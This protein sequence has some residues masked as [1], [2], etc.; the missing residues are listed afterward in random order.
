MPIPNKKSG[1]YGVGQLRVLSQ[2]QDLNYNVE[3]EVMRSG[4]NKNKWDY[5]NVEQ[6]ATTFR[7]QPILCAYV[8]GKIGDG[9]NM[10]ETISIDG[11]KRYSFTAPDAERIVGMIFDTDDAIRTVKKGSQTWV[12][13]KGKLWRFY[14]PE[15]VDK[16]AKQKRMEVSAETN[17]LE[18]VHEDGYDVFLKWYGV[19]VTILG[20]NV[21]PAIPGANIKALQAMEQSFKELC[22]KAAS[23]HARN[24]KNN[25]GANRIVNGMK[26]KILLNE[27]QGKF[28]DYKVIGMNDDG[29]HVVM[30]NNT[31]AVFTYCSKEDDHGVVIPERISPVTLNSTHKFEDGTAV[32]IDVMA[33]LSDAVCSVTDRAS[34]AETKVANLEAE[35]T[36]LQEQMKAMNEAENKRRTDE[37]ERAVNDAIE[38][39]KKLGMEMPEEVNSILECAKSGKY[40]NSCNEKGDWIGVDVAIN[41]VMAYIGRQTMK[42]NQQAADAQMNSRFNFETFVNSQKQIDGSDVQAVI[43]RNL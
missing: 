42:E 3:I 32:E 14:N 34:T 28:P 37:V 18:Q 13:A 17:I 30:V 5:R 21:S 26:N 4:P 25:E 33:M 36:K 20:D 27:I 22:L 2:D 16:I 8:N 24:E 39:A 10:R 41:E 15:L 43:A 31:G 6:Y 1:D 19:G 38:K 9:H 40:N 12:V 35:N 7:G 11:E 23:Y 29:S